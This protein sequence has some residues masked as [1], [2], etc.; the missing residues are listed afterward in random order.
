MK[1]KHLTIAIIFLSLFGLSFSTKNAKEKTTSIETINTVKIDSSYAEVYP[2]YFEN[3]CF[4][5]GLSDP[6]KELRI[7]IFNVNGLLI[8][9]FVLNEAL[10]SS[11]LRLDLSTLNEK[12]MIV[13]VYEDQELLKKI[14]LM[15]K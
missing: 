13:R 15:K 1:K 5:K 8:Q 14:R 2:T 10:S 12:I 9:T 11:E 3:E 7:E 4:I 6:E